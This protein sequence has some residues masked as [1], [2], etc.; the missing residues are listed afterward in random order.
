MLPPTFMSGEASRPMAMKGLESQVIICY[1]EYM[2]AEV[3][4]ENERVGEL[5]TGSVTRFIFAMFMALAVVASKSM[6]YLGFLILIGLQSFR[7]WGG[8]Y[9]QLIK[10]ARYLIWLLLFVFIMHLFLHPGRI[11][12]AIWF[13]KATIEG[14]FA[15]AFYGLKLIDFTIAAYIIFL[16]TD[17]FELISPLERFSRI[18]GSRGKIISSLAL[19]FFLAMRFLPELSKQGQMTLLAFK[20][21]GL[22]LKGGWRYKAKSITLILPPLFVNAFK[23]SEVTAAALNVKGYDTRHTRAVLPAWRLTLGDIVT[24]LASFV[25]LIAGWRTG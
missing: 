3:A 1:Y 12:F 24:I 11:L 7:A 18:F 17:P 25:I 20:S 9:R 4:Y 10:I 15:G 16:T 22:D 8:G 13:L 2:Q 6:V 5:S 23:R 19:A 14:V 21:K